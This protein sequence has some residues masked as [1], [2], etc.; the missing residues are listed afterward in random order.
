MMNDSDLRRRYTELREA[1]R[2]GAPALSQ[3]LLRARPD[4]RRLSIRPI[5]LVVGAVV[6]IAIAVSWYARTRPSSPPAIGAT[7]MTWR[8]PTDVFLRTPGREL[9]GAMP[10][11]DASVLDAMN[12][13]P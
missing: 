4:R 2:E 6:A 10:P 5:P 9:L 1:D 7:I 11:L 8:A 13:I 12:S 3:I